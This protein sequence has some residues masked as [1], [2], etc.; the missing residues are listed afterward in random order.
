[1]I[2]GDDFREAMARWAAGVA[3]VAVR[4]PDDG[5]VYGTTVSSLSSLSAEPPRILFSLGTGAQVL[6]FLEEETPFA[7]N[8]LGEDQRRLAQVFTD[9]F[10]VGPSP[11]P[12][13]GLPAIADAH[14]V[15]ECRVERLVEVAPSRLVVAAVE[16]ARL[17]EP[18]R[19]LVRYLRKYRGLD[20]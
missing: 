20:E 13:E 18:G 9:P 14:V 17:G 10:P 19:P 12:E 1:M 15:L 6:P 3:V 11:F 4:D 2:S 5:R 16:G 7:V 8:I